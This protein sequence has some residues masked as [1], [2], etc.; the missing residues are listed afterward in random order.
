LGETANSRKTQKRKVEKNRKVEQIP[1]QESYVRKVER[2]KIQKSKKSK[3]RKSRKVE[4]FLIFRETNHLKS[5]KNRKFEKSKP[6]D[7]LFFVKKI[8]RKVEHFLFFCFCFAKSFEKSN[9]F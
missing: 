4:H 7:F 2:M 6:F 5:P 1:G 8:T 9:A 3:N